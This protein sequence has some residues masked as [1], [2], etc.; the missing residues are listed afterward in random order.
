M[1]IS[2]LRK[3]K[4]IRWVC[5]TQN[6]A[7]FVSCSWEVTSKCLEF[8]ECLESLSLLFTGLFWPHLTVYV[9]VNEVTQDGDCQPERREACDVSLTAGRGELETKLSPV[10]N[11]SVMLNE[12][13]VK[14]LDTKAQV[15]FPGWQ[16]SAYCHTLM[17]Q[18]GNAS[19][20]TTQAS[21]LGLSQTLPYV[22]LFWMV[23]TC[24]YFYWKYCNLKYNVH[25]SSESCYSKL[26]NL[27]GVAGTPDGVASWPE[28][29]VALGSPDRG[30]GLV[31]LG[32]PLGTLKSRMLSTR[33]DTLDTLLRI[34]RPNI[35]LLTLVL[36]A[37]WLPCQ[38]KHVLKLR[39]SS[40]DG[41]G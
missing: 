38:T 33:C 7:G 19:L 34:N 25:L 16:Y 1:A 8:L 5:V 18:E 17:C 21:C 23:L 26:T 13:S 4:H 30:K 15:H 41:W 2:F 20:R 36:R 22:S 27:R 40:A 14:T 12:V 31:E 35:G 39:K 24:T 9:Y 29:K 37:S 28:V 11:D 10:A 6:L 32:L 3:G